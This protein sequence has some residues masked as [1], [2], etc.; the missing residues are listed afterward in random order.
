M[1]IP[2][3]IYAQAY[4]IYLL[5]TIPALAEPGIYIISAMYA[6]TA[7][8]AAMAIFTLLFLLLHFIKPHY[9]TVI[10]VLFV[11]VLLAVGTG[12]KLLLLDSMPGRSF[13]KMD[14]DTLFPIAAVLAG[15]IAVYINIP[16]IRDHFSPSVLEEEVNTIGVQP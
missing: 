16:R 10:T 3:I 1:K 5:L 9:T 4:G 15:C 13:W 8:L 12:F 2:F 7:G 14:G 11:G 6:F